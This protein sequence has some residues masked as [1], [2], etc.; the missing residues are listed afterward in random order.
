MPRKRTRARWRQQ[1]DEVTATSK[2]RTI[3]PVPPPLFSSALA[4][5]AMRAASP[6]RRSEIS[7]LLRPPPVASTSSSATSPPAPSRCTSRSS[8][9]GPRLSSSA[10]TGVDGTAGRADPALNVAA[11]RE[12][13]KADAGLTHFS[14]VASFTAE[15]SSALAWCAHGAH[16]SRGRWWA[17]SGRVGLAPARSRSRTQRKL[18]L[19]AAQ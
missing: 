11:R 12:M 1:A 14:N 5:S 18:P 7:A 6:A 17:R 3:P 15:T 4:P 2:K 16:R 10:R 19:S 9:P 8:R 13:P